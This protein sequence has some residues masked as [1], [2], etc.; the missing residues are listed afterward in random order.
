MTHANKYIIHCMDKIVLAGIEFQWNLRLQKLIDLILYRNSIP[1]SIDYFLLSRLSWLFEFHNYKFPYSL[2][3]EF[4]RMNFLDMNFSKN[5]PRRGIEPR[6]PARL[7][8]ILTTIL[9]RNWLLSNRSLFVL[10]NL[11][12]DC[13]CLWNDPVEWS[14]R[15][16]HLWVIDMSQRYDS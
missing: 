8:G 11:K 15:L 6:S 2:N 4:S 5:A 3:L 13:T 1:L 16:S 10:Q 9:S 14:L 12:C 7:A